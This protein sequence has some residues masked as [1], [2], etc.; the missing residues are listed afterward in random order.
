MHGGAIVTGWKGSAAQV[1]AKDKKRREVLPLR[2]MRGVGPSARAAALEPFIAEQC[3]ATASAV[4]G[5]LDSRLSSLPQ[6]QTDDAAVVEQALLLGMPGGVRIPEDNPSGVTLV[7][8]P[9]RKGQMA[10]SSNRSV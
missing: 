2:S 3:L 1:P 7:L 5:L 6:P 10:W 9:F 8:F 4:A